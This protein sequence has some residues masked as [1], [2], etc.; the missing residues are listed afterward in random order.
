MPEGQ[1]ITKDTVSRLQTASAGAC[2]CTAVVRNGMVHV[3]GLG[4]CRA[5][6]GNYSNGLDNYSNTRDNYSNTLDK[7]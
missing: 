5:V 3:A 6:L 7:L 2:A 4:D 1:R